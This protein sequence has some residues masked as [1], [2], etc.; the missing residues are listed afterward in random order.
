[1][2]TFERYEEGPDSA[3]ENEYWVC[4]ECDIDLDADGM[5]MSCGQVKGER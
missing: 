5:C 2:Q 4:K 1:M 3:Y